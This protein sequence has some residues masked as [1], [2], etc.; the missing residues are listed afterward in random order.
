M[1]YLFLNEYIMCIKTVII[2]FDISGVDEEL[3]VRPK[4][5]STVITKPDYPLYELLRNCTGLR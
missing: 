4:P 2:C 3:D 5:V 1:E